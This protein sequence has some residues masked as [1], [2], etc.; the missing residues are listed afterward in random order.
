MM[1]QKPPKSRMQSYWPVLGAL[2]IISCI[3]IAFVLGPPVYD[4]FRTSRV[5]RGFPPPTSE[6]PR[7]SIEWILR[8]VIFV[9]LGLFASLLVAAAAPKKKSAVTEVKL[10]KERQAMVN[11]KKARKMRQQLM[12]KQ[13]KGR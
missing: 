2:L 4:W 12:N 3:I 5:V 11:E 6:V 13:N 8:G 10:V 1:G 9:V 7:S